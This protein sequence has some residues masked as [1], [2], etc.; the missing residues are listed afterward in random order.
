[1]VLDEIMKELAEFVEKHE[2]V[3]CK[4]RGTRCVSRINKDSPWI[5]EE[6]KKEARKEDFE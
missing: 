2:G 1:M 5:C 4:C 6:C 3:Y